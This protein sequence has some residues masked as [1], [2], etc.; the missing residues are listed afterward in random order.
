MNASRL[1]RA[2]VSVVCLSLAILF[3]GGC[4]DSPQDSFDGSV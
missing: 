2:L 3:I 4:S 1:V